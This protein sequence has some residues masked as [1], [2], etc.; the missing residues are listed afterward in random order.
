VSAQV[1]K[2]VR[3][4]YDLLSVLFNLYINTIFQE[5]RMAINMG[6]QLTNRKIINIILYENDQILMASSED[7]LQTTAYHLNLIA[8][9]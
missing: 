3:Q 4:G 9:K 2:V 6:I 5:F 1:S 7:D 8:R